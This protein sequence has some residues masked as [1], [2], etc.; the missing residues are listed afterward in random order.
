MSWHTGHMAASGSCAHHS[1]AGS[2]VA[3]ND[4]LLLDPLHHICKRSCNNGNQAG[5]MMMA[6]H[7]SVDVS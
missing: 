7:G 2:I 5:A 1:C 4:V 6:G 3:V